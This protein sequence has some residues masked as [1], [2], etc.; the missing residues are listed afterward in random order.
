MK[1]F[2]IV[3]F[4]FFVHSIAYAL[5]P[6]Q[7]LGE[8]DMSGIKVTING[9]TYTQ[10]DFYSFSGRLSLTTKGFVMDMYA[11]GPAGSSEGFQC[12]FYTTSS[13]SNQLYISIRGGG[14]ETVSAT[15]SNGTLN[16]SGTEY[17]SGYLS[18]YEYTFQKTQ[19]YYTSSNSGYTQA[20]LD[21]AVLAAV[22]EKDAVISTL[23]T[24]AQVDAAVQA[25]EAAKDK[26]IQEKDTTISQLSDINGDNITTLRDITV[27]LQVLSGKR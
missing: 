10:N 7:L 15:Y 2:I 4:L 9:Q 20:Q 21:A 26:I 3:F 14:S 24:Q 11:S 12:G 13:N 27:G 19:A 22:A 8:Y 16:V 23:F 5:D 25:A 18:N 1:K 6:N 17:V